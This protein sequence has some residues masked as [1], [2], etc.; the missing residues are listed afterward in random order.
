MNEIQ[1][2]F[3]F[4][5]VCELGCSNSLLDNEHILNCSNM[6]VKW[7]NFKDILNGSL[8]KKKEILRIYQEN[9]EK[10]RKFLQDSV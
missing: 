8:K 2:N 5:Q 7:N 6:A 1:N 4:K 3:G 9:Q 10:R